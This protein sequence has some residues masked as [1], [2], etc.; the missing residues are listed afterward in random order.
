MSRHVKGSRAGDATPSRNVHAADGRG[1]ARSRT[2]SPL[3]QARRPASMMAVMPA[4]DIDGVDLPAILHRAPARRVS[5]L[6]HG[7]CA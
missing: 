7:G 4:A 6:Q 5:A 3:V 1:D 2:E